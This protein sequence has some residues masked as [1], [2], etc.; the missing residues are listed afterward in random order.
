[1]EGLGAW[2]SSLSFEGNEHDTFA[3]MVQC[4][5]LAEGCLAWNA[6]PAWRRFV[7]CDIR[8][9]LD[10]N[11][12]GAIGCMT[13]A[14]PLHERQRIVTSIAHELLPRW[15]GRTNP[16]VLGVRLQSL[17]QFRHALGVLASAMCFELCRLFV[18]R[19]ELGR[20]E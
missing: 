12:Y 18:E 20:S 2:L 16:F 4:A 19:S 1:M 7:S 17:L 9:S 13:V 14:A 11:A 15:P 10:G 8:T 5:R 3:F 6:E